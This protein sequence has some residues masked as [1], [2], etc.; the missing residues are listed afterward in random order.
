MRSPRA[1]SE[2]LRQRLQSGFDLRTSRLK[3]GRQRE[4]F[5]EGGHRLIGRKAGAVGGDLEQDAVGL[6]EIQAAEIKAVDLAG[7]A[8]AELVQPL[9]PGALLRLVRGAEGDVMHAAGA[10]PRHR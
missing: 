4:A 9:G 3:E 8:D 7:V 2:A 10:L 1:G 6:P 5:A